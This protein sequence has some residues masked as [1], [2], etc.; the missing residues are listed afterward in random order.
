VVSIVVNGAAS[1]LTGA[2]SILVNA[3]G[4]PD[5]VTLHDLTT[6]VT[7]DGGAGNDVLDAS[8]VSALGV[9]LR[10]GEGDDTLIAGGG[11]DTLDGGPG[12]DTAVLKGITPIAYWNLNETS[13][14]AIADS[15]GT[16]QNGTFYGS[17]PDLDDP[18][19]PASAAP[20]G[21]ATGADFHD[22]RQEYI[23]V[24][25][26]AAFE[27][28]EGTIQLWFNTRDA[29][30]RQTLFAKDQNG[31][32]NGLRIYLDDRD[33][34]VRLEVGGSVRSIDTD[35]TSH[36]NPV[37]SNTWYQLT[38]TFGAGGMKLYLDGVLVGANAYS[39]GLAGNRE[40]I[41]I[42]GSNGG[43]TSSNL[44]RL[45]ISEPFDGHIDEVAFYGVAL[46][47][48]QIAQ[49]RL[50]GAQG[51]VAPQDEAD[52][53]LGIEHTV[54]AQDPQVFTAARDAS[55]GDNVEVGSAWSERWPHLAGMVA[56]LNHHGLRELFDDL[57]EKGLELFGHTGGKP[58]L[59]SVEGVTLDE[60]GGRRPPGLVTRAR[61]RLGTPR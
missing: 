8:G 47:P 60:D 37:S 23:A 61:S 59:F 19:P 44:S 30:D 29:Y 15:A 4:G 13:G 43:N 52:T 55:T 14:A 24:A 34:K 35:G 26:D 46:T 33:L 25:H 16:P 21:A 53:L 18:G 31:S 9:V 56:G 32:S 3:L 39:G 57:R 1:T 27:V 48:Q 20:F 28:A 5:T 58:A 49:T 38:F 2:S 41:V 45:S 6:P 51:V 11:I 54:V 7:V 17:S 42:G 40:A 22:T 50:R 12:N 10:G 36:N